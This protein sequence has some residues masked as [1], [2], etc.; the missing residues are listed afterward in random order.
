MTEKKD[1]VHYM[2]F[3]LAAGIIF[4][5]ILFA[6]GMFFVADKLRYLYGLFLGSGLSLFLMFDMYYSVQR[7][8]GKYKDKAENY[9]RG[10]ALF[11][12]LI[13]GVGV[14]IALYLPNI[15]NMIALLLGSATL[16]LSAYM[17]PF[18][19]KITAK[20]KAGDYS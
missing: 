2:A 9:T 19:A 12:A 11:R 10:K 18:A 6:A 1:N 15:F 5:T 20:G 16:K 7:I 17:Q 4:Y 8:C 13:F 3:Y 14:G